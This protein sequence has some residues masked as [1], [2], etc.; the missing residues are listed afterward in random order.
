M[1]ARQ[2]PNCSSPIAVRSAVRIARTAH[3]LGIGTVGIYSNPTPTRS[4]RNAWTRRQHWA[5]RRR[6]S[7]YLRG[8]AII[9]PHTRPG[10]TPSIRIRHHRRSC[11]KTPPFLKGWLILAGLTWV[12]PTPEQNR[13]ARRQDQRQE[14]DRGGRR[15]V[16]HGDRRTAR[17]AACPTGSAC[18]FDQGRRRR[19]RPR[20]MRAVSDPKDLPVAVVRP[21]PGRRSPRSATPRCSRPHRAAGTWRCR[22]SVTRTATCLH[23]FDRECSIQRRNRRSSSSA[24]TGIDDATRQRLCAAA[25]ALAV[26]VGYQGAGTVEFFV[27]DDGVVV[28]RRS[29]PASGGAPGHRGHHRRRP[30]GTAVAGGRRGAT[31]THPDRHHRRRARHRKLRG[32]EDPAAGWLPCTGVLEEFDIPADVR[33]DSGRAGSVISSNYDSLLAKVIAHAPSRAGGGGHP[34]AGAARQPD[35]RVCRPTPQPDRDPRRT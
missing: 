33:L 6:P 2:L 19:R 17:R 10:A 15:R 23:F 22:S 16:D 14:E 29:T 20:G 31:A 35:F 26:H 1:S 5:A 4:M 13:P 32:G 3:R 27:G 7:P 9:W 21:R 24:R 28:F 30:G 18:P 25:V 11:V 34:G 8:D 12:G